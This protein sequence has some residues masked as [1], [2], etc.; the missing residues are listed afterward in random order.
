MKLV[1]V[2]LVV[3]IIFIVGVFTFSNYL[4]FNTNTDNDTKSTEIEEETPNVDEVDEDL[5]LVTNPEPNT[6]VDNPITITG[7]ARGY[8]FFEASFPIVVTDWK[9]LIIGEGYATADSDWMTEDYVPFTATVSYDL[10]ADTPY[11]RGYLILMKDN[12]S[13]LPEHDAAIDIPILFE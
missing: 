9:G 13:G 5:I 4:D 2:S 8:W 12:P 3:V 1:Y 6:V 10:P 11:M 7:E